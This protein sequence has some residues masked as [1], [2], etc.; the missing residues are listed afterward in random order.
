[1]AAS[2]GPGTTSR[3]AGAAAAHAYLDLGADDGQVGR[4]CRGADATGFLHAELDDTPLEP[5][6]VL[7]AE[8]VPRVRRYS[9]RLMRPI[10]IGEPPAQLA[11]VVAALFRFQAIQRE[12]MRPGVPA[13]QADAALRDAVLGAGLRERYDN[14]TGYMLGIYGRTPRSS[15]FSHV[16]L[17]TSDWRLE[18]G[19][20]FHM[21]AS[22]Q[23]IG[24]REIVLVTAGGGERLTRAPLEMLVSG[25]SG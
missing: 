17:P 18:A 19:M 25:G 14:V 21:Y 4:I 20:V 10:A 22:A 9:A 15:D 7:H 13:A 3:Q 23:G 11:S 16:F 1:M 2:I 5:G 24:V 12:A 6:D 8:L